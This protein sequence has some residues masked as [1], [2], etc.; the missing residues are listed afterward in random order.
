MKK[1]PCFFLVILILLK[2][3][4]L[5]AQV[6]YSIADLRKISNETVG[7]IESYE[8]YSRFSNRDDASNFVGIF[9]K[10]SAEH[11]NDIIPDN[12]M[13]QTLSPQKYIANLKKYFNQVLVSID[14]DSIA[15]PKL[16]NNQHT[17]QAFVKK[18]V[19]CSTT[20][21][22][23]NYKDTFN[24]AV[25][26]NF[27]LNN[28]TASNFLI[29]KINFLIPR[30][31][32]IYFR[33][34]NGKTSINEFDILINNKLYRSDASG[35]VKIEVMDSNNPFYIKSLDDV[36]PQ[37]YSFKN[38][39]EL[40]KS[41]SI[42]DTCT[43]I[44]TVD[45]LFKPLYWQFDISASGQL[46]AKDYSISKPFATSSINVD[47]DKNYNFG[48]K[49]G[50]RIFNNNKFT[51]FMFKTGVS[52]Q[53][54]SFSSYV[55]DIQYSYNEIDADRDTYLRLIQIKEL[56]EQTNLHYL[57]IPFA[58]SRA[59]SFSDFSIALGIE[60]SLLFNIKANSKLHSSAE[61]QG[62]YSQYFNL[63]IDQNGFYD[64]GKYNIEKDNHFNAKKN[65]F[66]TSLFMEIQRKIS[67]NSQVS[68]SLIAQ[69]NSS[70]IAEKSLYEYISKDATELHSLSTVQNNYEINSFLIQFA[71]SLNF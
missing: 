24:L 7:L 51:G 54:F 18:Y 38:F 15:F 47:Y 3:D 43:S 17:I 35:F 66:L 70:K 49:M 57:C 45:L 69:R 8:K 59:F 42:R 33:T 12:K 28:D 58:L 1:S 9:E 68:V 48:L 61:Y 11:V 65:L 10:S 55:E 26:I 60:Q 71:Y 19:E 14:I 31:R 39:E 40:E 6:S 46:W 29:K 21:C 56:N 62:Y 64:F 53:S 30:G 52:Y 22:N 67:N 63:T 4:M 16:V 23:V 25:D 32:F 41:C 27:D 20:N 34:H 13:D 44:L 36:F 5:S 2:A 37:T 50:Y